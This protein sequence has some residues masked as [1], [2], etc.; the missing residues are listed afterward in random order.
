METTVATAPT[1]TTFQFRINPKI[2]ERFPQP[3]TFIPLPKPTP[4]HGRS[5]RAHCRESARWPGSTRRRTR[6]R[7]TARSTAQSY[8]TPASQPET[9]NRCRPT[10]Y[11]FSLD[12]HPIIRLNPIPITLSNL[13]VHDLNL[14][15]GFQVV[16]CN[17]NGLSTSADFP[18]HFLPLRPNQMRLGIHPFAQRGPNFLIYDLIRNPWRSHSFPSTV[19]RALLYGL[20]QIGP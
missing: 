18:H 9:T 1:T 17:R 8:A 3:K 5:I 12:P 2:R 4:H 13:L 11:T 7:P 16:N 14:S 19:Y 20:K 15:F 6:T 10:T